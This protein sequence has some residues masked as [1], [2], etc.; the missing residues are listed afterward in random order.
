MTH[1]ALYRKS[2]QPLLSRTKY[3]CRIHKAVRLSTAAALKAGCAVE[4][5]KDFFFC[6]GIVCLFFTVL[7]IEP[8]AFASSANNLLLSYVPRTFFLELYLEI[9]SGQVTQ[10]GLKISSSSFLRFLSS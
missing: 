7:K 4:S 6:G 3:F 10:A 2:L 9:E 1:I 5:P 8:R